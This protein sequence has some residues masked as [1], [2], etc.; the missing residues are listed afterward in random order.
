M[1]LAATTLFPPN[2]PV[3]KGHLSLPF[4]VFLSQ[5]LSIP[6]TAKS[7]R[8]TDHD[9][10]SVCAPVQLDSLFIFSGLE[11]TWFCLGVVLDQPK[12][13]ARTSSFLSLPHRFS[14]RVSP[15]TLQGPGVG[16]GGSVRFHVLGVGVPSLS[17]SYLDVWAF[18]VPRLCRGCGF[19][20]VSFFP[21]LTL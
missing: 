10:P 5:K 21:F 16:V 14:P 20:A 6:K 19:H 11:Q 2:Q 7:S 17:Y 12:A 13:S 4:P 3:T 18:S 1:S 8:H 15:P 9:S